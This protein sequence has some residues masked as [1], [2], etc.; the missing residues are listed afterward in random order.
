MLKWLIFL[1]DKIKSPEKR[2]TKGPIN[3]ALDIMDYNCTYYYN[4]KNFPSMWYAGGKINE[5]YKIQ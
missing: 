5:K 3:R 2:Y 4:L 1:W